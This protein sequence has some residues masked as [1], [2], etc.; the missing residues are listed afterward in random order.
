MAQPPMVLGPTLCE[1]V[2]ADPESGHV[3]I[4]RVFNRLP[5]MTFPSVAPRF[6]VYAA[7]TDAEGVLPLD[8]VV[9]TGDSF[10]E[11]V[12]RVPTPVRFLG[13]LIVVHYTLRLRAC[14]IPEP[15]DYTFTL[16]HAGDWL[17]HRSLEVVLAEEEDP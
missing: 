10:L 15:G 11:E 7:L 1:E 16:E 4:L 14:P 6:C 9:R 17:A 12:H 13:R 8:L 5:V 2:V 3:S